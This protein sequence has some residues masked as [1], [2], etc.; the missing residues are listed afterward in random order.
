LSPL[1]PEEDKYLL[2]YDIT[3]AVSTADEVDRALA[4]L[5]D[6]LAD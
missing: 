6:F 1:L 3:A 5:A 2:E 4:A